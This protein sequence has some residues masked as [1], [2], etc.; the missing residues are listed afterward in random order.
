MPLLPK[1]RGVSELFSERLLK[2]LSVGR[3]R[4]L[5]L[6]LAF[7]PMDT[8]GTSL[9]SQIWTDIWNLLY[10]FIQI[11]LNGL[12]S[13]FTDIFSGF[14]QSIDY[15]FQGFGFSMSGYGVWGP[16]MFVVG[17]GVALLVGFL[18][19]AVIGPLKDLVGMEDDA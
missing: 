2:A 3:G 17:I 16:L 9:G 15:M 19:F 7:I 8:T 14:G 11:I 12:G 4:F 18:I 1:R 13:L 6:S 10:G 5:A